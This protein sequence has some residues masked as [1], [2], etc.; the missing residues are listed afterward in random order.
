[1]VGRRASFHWDKREQA[2][3][4]ESRGRTPYFRGIARDD[5]AGIAAAFAAHLA[6][7]EAA[8]RPPEPTAMDLCLAFVAAARGVRARTA[9]THKERLLKFCTH[10][11]APGEILAGR[12][13]STLLAADLRGALREWERDGHTPHYRAGICRSVK[14]AFAWAASEDGGRLIPADPFSGVESPKIARSP[15]RYAERVEVAAF[16]RFAWRRVG[17]A[18]EVLDRHRAWLRSR[19]EPDDDPLPPASVGELYRRFGRTLVLMLRVGAHTGARPGELASAW[20]GDVDW[21]RGTITLPPERHKTGSKT[22]RSR[23]IHLGARSVLLR[24][25]RRERDRPGRHPTSIFTHKRGRGGVSRGAE[26]TAGEPWGDFTTLPGGG[27]GFD[28][29]TRPL[30]QKLGKL[31][32]MAIAEARALKAA[33]RPA[34]GL[35][36]IRAEGANRFVFYRLRHTYISDGLMGGVRGASIAELTGTSERMITQ[37]YGHLLEDHLRAAAEEIRAGRASGRGRGGTGD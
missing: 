1:M 7:L 28:A 2:Y 5:H 23:V 12:R 3:R 24:A 17:Y 31:R 11:D 32:A 14:A 35:E 22:G 13:A 25:L 20:W 37:V 6:E 34:R 18:P 33:G 4:S 19:G 15:E 26:A 21:R 8:S 9:R 16:L 10:R 36:L 30:S 29:D 27:P